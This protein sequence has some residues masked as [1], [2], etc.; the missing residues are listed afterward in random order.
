LEFRGKA[1]MVTRALPD[2]G[3]SAFLE[4]LKQIESTT[5]TEIQVEKAVNLIN[6]A[7]IFPSTVVLVASLPGRITFWEIVPGG[8]ST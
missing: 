1:E 8:S 5:L 7:V 4:R 3:E 2:E 6:E